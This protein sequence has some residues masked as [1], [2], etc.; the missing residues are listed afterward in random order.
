M[1]SVPHKDGE[2][3]GIKTEDQMIIVFLRIV[4]GAEEFFYLKIKYSKIYKAKYKDMK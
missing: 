3:S 1:A 2:K 4:S